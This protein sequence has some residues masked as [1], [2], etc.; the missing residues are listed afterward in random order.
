[1]GGGLLCEQP[2]LDSAAVSAVRVSSEK[3]LI[4]ANGNQNSALVQ[5]LVLRDRL[6]SAAPMLLLNGIGGGRG[7]KVHKS[8]QSAPD[9]LIHFICQQ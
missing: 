1:M 5:A 3:Q 6:L 4:H 2:V 8:P 9:P 7:L